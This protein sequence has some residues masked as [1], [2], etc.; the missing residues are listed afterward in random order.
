MRGEFESLD[1]AKLY[2][3]LIMRRCCHYAYSSE[4]CGRYVEEIDRFSQAFARLYASI[5]SPSSHALDADAKRALCLRMYALSTRIM[6]A[7][8]TFT[9]EMEYDHF[10]PES[11]DR[12]VRRGA[13]AVL[14]RN[15][16]REAAWDRAMMAEVGAWVM[17]IEE[18]GLVEGERV[19]EERRVR[20]C[21]MVVDMDR[22]R[23]VVQCVRRKCGDTRGGLEWEEAVI[24]V[25]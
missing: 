18:R 14:R 10:L 12:E 9:S 25:E 21:R 23:A 7:G 20:L 19:A 2:W 11:R 8:T 13:L 17:G 5:T 4:E 22:R 3:E 16:N 15:P 24:D 1:E 6:V